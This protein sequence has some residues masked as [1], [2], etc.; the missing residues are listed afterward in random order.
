M[1]ENHMLGT[2]RLQEKLGEGGMGVVYRALDT[3]L[4]RVVAI[5]TLL[6]SI[7]G[8]PEVLERFIREAKAASRLQHPAIVI[9]YHIGVQDTTRY[10]V[11]EYVEG[12]TLKKAIVGKPRPVNQIG[13]LG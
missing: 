13:D 9:I 10:I 5:K 12:K 3:E 11:M 1:Q 6:S 2:Y 4:D 7:V 8:D